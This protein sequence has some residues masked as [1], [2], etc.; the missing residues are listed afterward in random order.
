MDMNV[1]DE[2]FG[3]RQAVE[4]HETSNVKLTMRDGRT[5]AGLLTAVA[6]PDNSTDKNAGYAVV[7]TA[8]FNSE[9]VAVDLDAIA[10]VDAE[11]KPPYTTDSRAVWRVASRLAAWADGWR[12]KRL[13]ELPPLDL[14]KGLGLA[15]ALA[16]VTQV[17]S[18]GGQGE[19]YEGDLAF[20]AEAV[21]YA[22]QIDGA[23]RM[24]VGS[25]PS[26]AR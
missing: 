7:Y 15:H 20:L 22:R 8:G 14:G 17:E 2:F 10:T 12:G 1:F 6:R 3:R 4:E 5:M 16:A 25:M 18:W 11:P 21:E 26:S 9:Y 23:F 19:Q 13:T 24:W